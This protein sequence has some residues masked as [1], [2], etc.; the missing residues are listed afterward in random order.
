M[1]ISAKE[2]LAAQAAALTARIARLEAADRVD[3]ANLSKAARN[4]VAGHLALLEKGADIAACIA[5][6][7]AQRAAWQEARAAAQAHGDYARVAVEDAK[8]AALDGIRDAYHHESEESTCPM[9]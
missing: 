1:D 4:I 8:L 7:I 6:V 9:P 5:E 3:E 2:A